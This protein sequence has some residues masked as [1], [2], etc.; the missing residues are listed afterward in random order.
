MLTFVVGVPVTDEDARALM[1]KLMND[2]N[3]DAM[4]AARLIGHAVR[5]ETGHVELTAQQREAILDVLVDSPRLDLPELR[6]ALMMQEALARRTAG[7]G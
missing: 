1:A 5:V 3:P 7:F 4:A 6:D 2:G